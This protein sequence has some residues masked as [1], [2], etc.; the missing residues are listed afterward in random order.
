MT[1]SDERI[2]ITWLIMPEIYTNATHS[3]EVNVLACYRVTRSNIMRRQ[4]TWMTRKKRGMKEGR[5]NSDSDHHQNRMACC[6]RDIP[7]LKNFKLEW[8]SVESVPPPRFLIP[9]KLLLLNKHRIMHVVFCGVLLGP[10]NPI[11]NRIRVW[12]GG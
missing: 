8:H 9:N 3:N 10:P 5:T 11:R 7:L 2:I 4:S 6:L 12:L 1:K